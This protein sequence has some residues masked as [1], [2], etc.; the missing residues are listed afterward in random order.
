M[1][2]KSFVEFCLA[3]AVSGA[4]VAADV[5]N[6]AD[7]RPA[8]RPN[9]VVVMADDMGYSDA[10][11]YGGEVETPNIDALA[12]EGVRFTSFYNCSRCCQ[13]RASM[14]TGAYPHRVGMA[15]FGQTMDRTVPTVVESLKTAG[16][17]TGMVGKWHLTKLPATD[18]EQDRIRWMNHRLDLNIPFGDIRSYP[19]RRGFEKFYGIIWGVVDH[20][21]PFSLTDGEQPVPEVPEDF[22]FTDAITRRSVDQIEE[23]SQRDKPFMMYVAYTAPH[24]P[25]HARQ[26]DIAKYSGR[27]D[28]GWESIRKSRSQRQ[29]E[30][31]VI[32]ADAPLG[33][34]SARRSNWERLSPRQQRFQAAKM[35]VHAAMIDRVDQGVGQIVEKLRSTGQLE[36]TV[37][38][39][40]SDNGASPEIPGHAGYDRNGGTRDGRDSLR[41][42]EL[43]RG[44]NV[45]KVGTEESYAG[46]GPSWASVSNTPL[47]YWKGESYDGGCR[48]PMIVHWPAGLRVAAGEMTSEVGHV[49]DLAPTWLELA[50][51]EPLPGSL[52]DGVSLAPV[53]AGK[54]LDKERTLYFDHQGG[55]GV[56]KG[57]WKASKLSRGDWQLFDIVADPAETRDL[58]ESR[59]PVLDALVQQWDS[60]LEQV[61]SERKK[62]FAAR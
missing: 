5:G 30:L 46:I 16:Y 33:E 52:L 42:A 27:Y 19:T 51:A 23:F 21:D 43:R 50:G 20:F 3:V 34:N 62:E 45:E 48:T 57:R 56:R 44:D 12:S 28:A 61:S 35:E 1:R 13:T 32:P 6:A 36:N 9:I 10:G 11:C 8:R 15:E 24:W 39:F 54:V 53:L 29:A 2:T 4:A 60:W 31:G 17:S 58:A 55:H 14:V 25:L 22:Y 37:V 7:E 59:R 41:E 38:F 49:I 40:L 47:R 18:N 26:E